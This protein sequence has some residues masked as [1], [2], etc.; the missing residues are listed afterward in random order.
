M[1]VT[2]VMSL[3]LHATIVVISHWL[4]LSVPFCSFYI[5]FVIPQRI[6]LATF[7]RSAV[8]FHIAVACV[9][10][11]TGLSLFSC[12]DLSDI[13]VADQIQQHPA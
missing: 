2:T 1:A 9:G 10:L 4:A 5:A 12:S 13:L 7:D 11:S 3:D 8:R 6:Q